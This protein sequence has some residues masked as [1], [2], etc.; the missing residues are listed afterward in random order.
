[1]LRAVR[2]VRLSPSDLPTFGTTADIFLTEYGEQLQEVI[3][4]GGFEPTAGTREK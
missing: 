1:M 4:I 2:L 3:A